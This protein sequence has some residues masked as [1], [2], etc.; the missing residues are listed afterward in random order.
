MVVVSYGGIY[1][2]WE[3]TTRLQP[4]FCNL[5]EKFHNKEMTLVSNL[6]TLYRKS[7]ALNCSIDIVAHN[8]Y[9]IPFR[10]FLTYC[11]LIVFAKRRPYW[12]V[13]QLPGIEIVSSLN[14]KWGKYIIE[15]RQISIGFCEVQTFLC[16]SVFRLYKGFIGDL[17]TWPHWILVCSYLSRCSNS[18]F[19]PRIFSLYHGSTFWNQVFI[20]LQ[21]K[22]LQSLLSHITMQSCFFLLHK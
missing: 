17:L 14:L 16:I 4:E 1:E 9:Y 13:H 11:H 5:K 8:E 7:V 18:R 19:G 2:T 22:S 3:W 10:G 6:Q 21:I 15:K 12:A 20:L